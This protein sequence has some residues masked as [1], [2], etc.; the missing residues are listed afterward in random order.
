MGWWETGHNDDIIGDGVA[1][2]VTLLMRQLDKPALSTF[3]AS[4]QAAIH[5]SGDCV[6]SEHNLSDVVIHADGTNL[7]ELQQTE[8]DTAL[9]GKIEQGLEDIASHY[10]TSV[11]RLPRLSE[12]LAAFAFVVGASPRKYLSQLPGNAGIDDF[13]ATT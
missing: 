9:T 11:D 13:H 3:I 4:L 5:A 10:E 8:P 12:V 7:P 2:T 1:D 6:Q